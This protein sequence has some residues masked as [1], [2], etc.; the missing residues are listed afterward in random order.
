MVFQ[1]Q[2]LMILII[3][4]SLIGSTILAGIPNSSG[5]EDTQIPDWIKTVAGWWA[6]DEI[7]EVE[8]LTGIEYLIN[9]NIISLNFVPCHGIQN[10]TNSSSKSVPN[11]IKNN[12]NWWSENLIDDIDFI[13]G[14]QYLIEHKIIKIDNKK[15]LGQVPLEDIKF[16]TEWVTDK[17]FLVF[18]QSSFFEYMEIV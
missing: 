9:N 11:W 7:S 2:F 17:S 8:F 4:S 14:I 10:Q 15:I 6:N 5:Q 12:A 1:T 3:S 16:S 13:N 18:A